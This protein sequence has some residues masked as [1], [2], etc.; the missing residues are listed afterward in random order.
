MDVRRESGR[1]V[2]VPLLVLAVVVAAALAVGGFVEAFRPPPARHAI[3]VPPPAAALSAVRA[4]A[5]E[6][7][8]DA[9]LP[10][11]TARRRQTWDRALPAHGAAARRA[12]DALYAH[13]APIPW[14]SLHVLVSAVDGQ[15]GV[16]DVKFA[17]RPGG[18]GPSDRVVAE[19]LLVV[20]GAGA[21]LRVTGDRSPAAM[22]R[23]YLMAFRTPRAVVRDGAVVVSDATWRPLALELAGDMPQAR[24]DVAA[25]LGVR[26]D[27][28]IVVFLY[29]APSEV[30]GYL[31]QTH[32]LERERFFARLP[33]TT[34]A[35]L[36]SPTDVGVL[37]SALPPAD[38]WTV[39]MLAHEVTHTLTWRWFYRTA[40][41]PPLLLEGM[42][43]AVEGDRSYAPLRAEVTHGNRSMPLLATFAR[44]DL[45]AS[46]RMSRITLAYLEGGALVKYV[47]AGWGQTA[48]RRFSVDVAQSALTGPAVKQVV[49]RDLHESWGRFYTGWKAYVM[50][51]P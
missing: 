8:I 32:A 26:G 21:H 40:H 35:T 41:A 15:A 22:R 33:T 10:A 19:R 16:F 51:L 42:A 34:Q 7:W 14:R 2:G 4:A 1:A 13:L 48:L 3:V 38:P 29:A 43:T 31:G 50:T 45:W 12:L 28:A 11:L 27:R 30:T 18:A 44:T 6:R 37:A 36:W 47:L 9:G 46:G 49:R 5:V 23:E 24:A 39:H 25:M 20:A 17:G